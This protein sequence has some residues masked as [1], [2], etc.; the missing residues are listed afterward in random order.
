MHV[1]L[2]PHP[3]TP[4][5]ALE[6]LEASISWGPDGELQLSYEA[7]GAISELAIPEPAAPERTDELWR[8]TCFEAFLR[9]AAGEAYVEIN[10]SPSG[11]WAA[12][13]F[14]GYRE[15]MTQLAPI[16]TRS[17]A[18]RSTPNVL[19]IDFT[20]RAPDLANARRA[21]LC[22][23][24]EEKSGRKSYWALAHPAGAPDFHHAA[25]L[26]L[27]LAPLNRPGDS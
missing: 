7:R 2:G 24:I 13:R 25:G 27:D 1:R 23:V 15:G 16:G 19:E 9:S 8:H 11:A 3:L 18:L 6:S 20:L 14:S 26:V 10:V 22:A 5:D 21:A 12:Y 17:F 4:C